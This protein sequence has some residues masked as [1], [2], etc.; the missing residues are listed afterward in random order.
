MK[1]HEMNLIPFEK[2]ISVCIPQLS[3]AF[4]DNDG[5]ERLLSWARWTQFH[6]EYDFSWLAQVTSLLQRRFVSKL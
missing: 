3:A 6:A 4:E 2:A 5:W 1:Q